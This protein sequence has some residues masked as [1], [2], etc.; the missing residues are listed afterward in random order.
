MKGG[1]RKMTEKLNA[2]KVSLSLAYTTA[3]VSTVCALLLTIFPEGA[4]NL[5]G[6]V[7]HGLDISQI[8]VAVSWPSALLGTIVAIVLALII[9]WLFS[10]I[11]NSVKG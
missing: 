10:K 7:F 11:Y 3:I 2:K 8:A 9:G 5:F 6:S 4:T 1:E